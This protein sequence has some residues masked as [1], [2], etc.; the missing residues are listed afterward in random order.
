MCFVQQTEQAFHGLWG[1][2][3]ART[4]FQSQCLAAKPRPL[5]EV[6]CSCFVP[7]GLGYGENHTVWEGLLL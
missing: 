4:G 2:S 6:L 1:H 7:R 5:G 3:D